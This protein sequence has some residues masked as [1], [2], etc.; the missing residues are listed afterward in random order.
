[1]SEEKVQEPLHE[2]GVFTSPLEDH[3]GTVTFPWPFMGRHYKQWL[4]VV[5]SEVDA[6]DT[7]GN[8]PIML[9]WRSALAIAEIDVLVGGE[10]LPQD[11]IDDSG[12]N[13]PLSVQAWVRDCAAEYLAEQLNLKNSPGE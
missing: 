8:L 12:D 3:P 11:Q 13:V 4:K 1:M 10:Q 9:E 6:D 7:I 5:H 2:E